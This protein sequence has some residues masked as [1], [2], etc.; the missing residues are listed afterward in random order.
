MARAMATL[1][2]SFR[3]DTL[4]GLVRAPRVCTSAAFS[5][6]SMA[7]R[8]EPDASGLAVGERRSLL[9]YDSRDAP[10]GCGLSVPLPAVELAVPLFSLVFFASCS[11][12][13]RSSSARDAA[14]EE[15]PPLMCFFIHAGCHV[16]S[17]VVGL[18][19]SLLLASRKLS[20]GLSPVAL[21]AGVTRVGIAA[22]VLLLSLL[23]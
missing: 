15:F 4:F 17:L 14:A 5:M 8:S 16:V 13:Q 10:T 11:S 21:A 19:C 22:P 7:T 20:R 12:I 2:S 23:K 9:A 18:F 1:L 3:D 6:S